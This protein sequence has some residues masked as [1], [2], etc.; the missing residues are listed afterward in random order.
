ML[1]DVEM[2]VQKITEIRCTIQAKG[3]NNGMQPR[4]PI[5][6]HLK[7]VTHVIIPCLCLNGTPCFSTFFQKILSCCKPVGWG[8]SGGLDE[9]PARRR[10]SVVPRG[11]WAWTWYSIVARQNE[12]E[13]KRICQILKRYLPSKKKLHRAIMALQLVWSRWVPLPRLQLPS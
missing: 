8:G 7:W 5:S 6:L 10:G 2:A 9:L 13:R 1:K 11:E 4:N 3:G 12:R